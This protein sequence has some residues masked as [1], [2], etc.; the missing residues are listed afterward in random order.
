MSELR[1]HPFLGEWVVT[2]THRQDRTFF[3]PPDYCPLCPTKP[4]G[5]PTEIPFDDYDIAVFENKFPS[6]ATPPRDPNIASLQYVSEVLPSNGVCEVV[7]YTPNHEATFAD[8]GKRK[9]AQLIEVW[10]DR[11]TDLIARDDVEYVFIFENK[12]AEIGVTLT[13]PHGQIYGYPFIPEVCERRMANERKHFAEHGEQLCD[14]WLREEIAD[15]RRIVFRER[16]WVAH[17]PF[18]ARYP[19]EVHVVPES[20]LSHLG[21][22]GMQDIDGLASALAAVTRAYDRLFGFPLPYMMGFYQH[23]EPATR[24][25]AQF[26]PPHRTAEKLKFLAGSEAF[27][28]VFIVDAL[29]EQTAAV[30][31]DALAKG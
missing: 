23:P 28:G 30:L 21:E 6:F 17:V 19:Y 9:I 20:R 27:C 15:G 22:F 18:F 8:L 12:G 2:A 16:G 5:H 3:P 25:V 29:P 31:R 24:F 11:Y 1:R 14:T 26:T 7:C 13:H 4:G 10:Q